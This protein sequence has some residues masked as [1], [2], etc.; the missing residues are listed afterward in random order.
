MSCGAGFFGNGV[1]KT[2]D[3]LTA[4]EVELPEV[5][6]F[7]Y[8]RC[9]ATFV[10]QT[11]SSDEDVS[12]LTTKL[13]TEL[14]IE[15]RKNKMQTQQCTVTTTPDEHGIIVQLVEQIPIIVKF[16]GM[17]RGMQ[18]L[19]TELE[20]HPEKVSL[21][22][23]SDMV[24]IMADGCKIAETKGYLKKLS[25]QGED[26]KTWCAFKK[27]KLT[28]RHTKL[29]ERMVP[30]LVEHFQCD[31]LSKLIRCLER[32]AETQGMFS[33]LKF[34]RSSTRLPIEKFKSHAIGEEA[35]ADGQ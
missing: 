29:A 27:E 1:S 33:R 6:R 24:H 15:D 30:V 26:E 32:H 4:L 22:S 21:M 8:D 23:C 9:L 13:T 34:W 20:E 7:L 11:I 31:H 3:M 16:Y 25:L 12:K 5:H 17:L 19:V 2:S 14:I 35:G 28:L 10:D 18:V